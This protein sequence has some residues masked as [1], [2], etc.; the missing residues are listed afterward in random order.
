MSVLQFT[1]EKSPEQRSED[2]KL[3][4]SLALA[5]CEPQATRINES[6]WRENWLQSKNSVE[7][8]QF[9]RVRLLPWPCR[10]TS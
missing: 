1:K 3:L 5:F 6:W 4:R 8:S 9:G 10:R 7:F 2:F